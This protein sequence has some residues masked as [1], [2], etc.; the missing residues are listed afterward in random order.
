[1]PPEL[2]VS[3]WV[4]PEIGGLNRVIFH[5][6]DDGEFLIGLDATDT[7][8]VNYRTSGGAWQTINTGRIIPPS[9]WHHIAFS[10]NST[11]DVAYVYVDSKI[12][13]ELQPGASLYA[14]TDDVTIGS[15]QGADFFTGVIDEVEMYNKS[16]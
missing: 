12:T 5:N 1:M 6:G 3:L 10:W 11:T 16:F 2:A 7:V 13:N 9:E 15:S 14:G 4:Q 8:Y